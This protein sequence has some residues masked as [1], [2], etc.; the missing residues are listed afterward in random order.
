[1]TNSEKLRALADWFDHYDSLHTYTPKE[2]G[3][4]VQIDLR[5][6]ANEFEQL[7]KPVVMQAEESDGVKGA[8]VGIG[9]W[10][11]GVRDWEEDFAH[12]NGNYFNK[13]VRCNNMFMGHK[14]RVVCKSCAAPAEAT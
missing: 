1:M 12:E 10:V 6:M 9:G 11:R 14:R 3:K 4:Q 8:A 7:N 2:G 13:C 5:A